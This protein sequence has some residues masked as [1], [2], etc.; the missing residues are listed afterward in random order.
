[1]AVPNVDINFVAVLASAV[2]A[3]IIG[4]LWYSPILFGNAWMKAGGINKKDIEK[5]K[6]KWMGKYYFVSFLGGLLMAY[7]LAHFM[8]Y[9]T[10]QTFSDGMQAGFWIWVGF[11]VPVSLGSVLWEGKSLKFYFINIGYYLVSLISMGG[12]LASWQ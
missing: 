9:L 4:G 5:S 2:V 1:M 7:V 8:Q 6:K 12:I 10:A 3:F 11:I